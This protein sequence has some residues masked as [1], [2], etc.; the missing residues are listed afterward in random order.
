MTN[1]T[2]SVTTTP[3]NP[4]R[5]AYTRAIITHSHT[6]VHLSIFNMTETTEAI[7][8]MTQPITMKLYRIAKYPALKALKNAAGFPL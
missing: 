2:R 6:A 5:I 3:Q 8:L 1:W 7:A 4:E